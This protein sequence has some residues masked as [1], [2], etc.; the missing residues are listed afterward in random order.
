[1]Y[2]SFLEKVSILGQL[3]DLGLVCQPQW[4]APL[5]MHTCS[6]LSL[7]LWLFVSAESLD[8]WERL[9]VADAL[10]PCQFVDGEEVV[11]QGEPGDDFF[12]I[13]EVQV[14]PGPRRALLYTCVAMCVP[15]LAPTHLGAMV[16]GCDL[17]L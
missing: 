8:K 13:I 14:R 9:T 1:M 2:E 15:Y 6:S 4:K 16:C 11:K 10:E 5:S 3:I 17:V 12:I 7:S